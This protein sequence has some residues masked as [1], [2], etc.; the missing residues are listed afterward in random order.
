[1]LKMKTLKKNIYEL[2]SFCANV[3]EPTRATMIGISSKNK[4][5][6]IEPTLIPSTN[7]A[8]S[9]RMIIISQHPTKMAGTILLGVTVAETPFALE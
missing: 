4:I 7:S 1:M 5:R 3:S 9:A 6:P 8:P 2:S